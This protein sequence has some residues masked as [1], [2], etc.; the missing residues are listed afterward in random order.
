MA[1]FPFRGA[2]GRIYDFYYIVTDNLLA[3][4]QQGG[5]YLFATAGL[6]EPTIIFV[7]EA[8]SLRA[9]I[10][11]SQVW[12]VAKR[13]Y[14]ADIVAI[15]VEKDPQARAE[16]LADLVERYHPPLNAADAANEDQV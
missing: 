7:G 9:A 4:P 3:V 5:N 15:H 11:G 1:G 12:E 8:R 16:K 14:V 2:T 6:R 10:L 13:D